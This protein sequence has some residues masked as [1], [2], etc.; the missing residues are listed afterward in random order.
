MNKFKASWSGKSYDVIGMLF[1]TNCSAFLYLLSWRGTDG[2]GANVLMLATIFVF[3]KNIH[4]RLGYRK[5]R[6]GG[7]G[8]LYMHVSIVEFI[9]MKGNLI[10]FDYGKWIRLLTSCMKP[11]KLGLGFNSV[12]KNPAACHRISN[13]HDSET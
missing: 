3:V 11:F 12:Q 6:R 9:L 5:G 1:F 2:S 10:F 4:W 8:W 7:G 13:A